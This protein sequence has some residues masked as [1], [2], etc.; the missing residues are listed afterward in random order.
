METLSSNVDVKLASMKDQQRNLS[1][2][3]DRGMAAVQNQQT[4]FENIKIT[5]EGIY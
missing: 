1:E 4:R 5:K 2:R 3:I